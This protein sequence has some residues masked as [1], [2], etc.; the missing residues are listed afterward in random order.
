MKTNILRFLVI[1]MYLTALAF[2]VISSG[3]AQSTTTVGGSSSGSGGCCSGVN[4]PAIPAPA[5]TSDSGNLTDVGANDVVGNMTYIG[6]PYYSGNCSYARQSNME[7]GP[8]PNA[9]HISDG[10]GHNDARCLLG[11]IM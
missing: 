10:A 3:S 11:S 7:F 5:T 4:I 6:E 9:I 1:S 2:L 8:G